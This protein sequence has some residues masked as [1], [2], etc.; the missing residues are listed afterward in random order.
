MRLSLLER[1]RALREFTE[2]L[3]D[4]VKQ[5]TRDLQNAVVAAEEANRA[6]SLF[7]ANMSHEASHAAQWRDRNGRAASGYADESAAAPVLRCRQGSAHSLLDLINDILD[8]SKIEAGKLEL[9]PPI[10]IS[11][12][13][14]RASPKCSVK[15]RMPNR[16]N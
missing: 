2:T 8:F 6:K 15:K 3:Q 7:L 4:Q 11:M 10:L 5:R 1:E 9:E 13:S 12:T 16:S 14:S